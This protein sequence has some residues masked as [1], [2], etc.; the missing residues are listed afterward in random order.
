[1]SIKIAIN[2]FGRVG[3]YLIRASLGRDDVEITAVNTRA[4]ADTLCHLLKYD[5]VHG[6]CNADVTCDGNALV[7]DDKIMRYGL[8]GGNTLK[9]IVSFRYRQFWEPILCILL[10]YWLRILADRRSALDEK[11]LGVDAVCPGIDRGTDHHEG[12]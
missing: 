4:S 7:V 10:L 6:K 5:S 12:K 1:M 2:G 9:L 8:A 11:R 3:R